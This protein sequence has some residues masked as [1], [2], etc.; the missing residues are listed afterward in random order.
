MP[1]LK[2]PITEAVLDIRVSPRADI[3]VEELGQLSK[4]FGSRYPS[5]EDVLHFTGTYE[6]GSSKTE[7]VTSEKIGFIF[8]NAEQSKVF[9]AQKLGFS[10]NKLAP[11]ESW[12]LFS[13]EAKELWK[14][15]KAIAKPLNITRVGLRYINKL[16]LPVGLK[17]FGKYLKQAPELA[18]GLPQGLSNFFTQFQIPYADV[19]AMLIINMTMAPPPDKETASVILDLDVFRAHSVPQGDADLWA[20]FE[21]LRAKKNEAFEACITDATRELFK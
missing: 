12:E 4:I 15:Y 19:E 3:T 8:K 16:N 6:I 21:K 10:F 1:Y 20:Y 17:D 9:Q 18:P 5:S 7:P 14:Q 2:A 13:A 11:Y